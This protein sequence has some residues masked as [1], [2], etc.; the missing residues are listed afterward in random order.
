MAE[1]IT[2][3]IITREES[4]TLTKCHC[5]GSSP[6]DSTAQGYFIYQTTA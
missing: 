3:Q 1:G 2:S 5:G 4:E 6:G